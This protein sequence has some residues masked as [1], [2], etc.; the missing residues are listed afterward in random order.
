MI[1]FIRVVM[2]YRRACKIKIN[3]ISTYS[4]F[5]F[6]R[7]MTNIYVNLMPKAIFE[8]F[9]YLI[10]YYITYDRRYYGFSGSSIPLPCFPLWENNGKYINSKNNQQYNTLKN[11]GFAG[12]E[13]EYD[14][15][16]GKQ[17]KYGGSCTDSQRERKAGI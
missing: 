14:H 4:P 3:G 9:I 13:G 15:K 8:V 10:N 5:G 16:Q 2:P 12:T 17:K 11:C 7:I 6:N 1:C